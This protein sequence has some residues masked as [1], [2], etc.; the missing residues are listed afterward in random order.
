MKL[1]KRFLKGFSLLIIVAINTIVWGTSYL[2]QHQLQAKIV[3]ILCIPT[4]L[5]VAFMR[6][7]SLTRN[8]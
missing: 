8:K 3:L 2:V 1:L 6:D 7:G 5:G 4:L